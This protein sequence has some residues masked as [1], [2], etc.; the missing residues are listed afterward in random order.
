L[1]GLGGSASGHIVGC[2]CAFWRG[3]APGGGSV[4]HRR[5][6]IAVST[7]IAASACAIY[8]VSAANDRGKCAS[9]TERAS[10]ALAPSPAAVVASRSPRHDFGFGVRTDVSDATVRGHSAAP[11]NMRGACT[12]TSQCHSPS[13]SRAQRNV[14]LS[15]RRPTQLRAVRTQKPVVAPQQSRGALAVGASASI[16]RACRMACLLGPTPYM[17]PNLHPAS[18][19]WCASPLSSSGCFAEADLGPR[20]QQLSEVVALNGCHSTLF[21]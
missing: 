5:P 11:S 13:T 3:T 18:R 19:S 8:E 20:W 21:Y 10:C 1:L 4:R 15:S 6:P 7:M 12:S 14:A 9:T 16:R 17:P 2:R